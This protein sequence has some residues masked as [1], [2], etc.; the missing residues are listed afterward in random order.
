MSASRQLAVVSIYFAFA[1]LLGAQTTGSIEGVITDSTQ[2]SISGAAIMLRHQET[3][4][5]TATLTN[6][7]GYFLAD[8][9]PSG[10]YDVTANHP[11]FKRASLTG[12]RL[13]VATR[14]RHDIVLTVGDVSESVTVEAAAVHVNTSNATVS[15]VIT[16]KQIDT[17]VLNGRHFSRLAMLVPGAVYHS[18]S[19]ELFGAGLGATGSPVSINGV[20]NKASGWFVDG[21]YNMNVGNGEANQHVP[22]IDSLS[23]VQV[24]TAN[25]SARYGTTGGSV[26]TAI[27]KSGT[28]RFHGGAY[29]YLRND[30]LDARNFFSPSNPP[31]KQNQFG[32]LIG[33][34][35]ILPG[36][37]RDRNKTFF[38]WSEDWRKRRNALTRITATPD[39]ALREGN[40]ASE[41]V[42]T[43][44]PLLD[45][46]TGQRFPGN[47]IPAGRIDPNARLLLQTYFPAPNYFAEPFRNYL[48]NGVARFDTR[49][50]TVK[51]DH[52]ITDKYRLSGVISN[53]DINVL[54][55]DAG[56]GGSPFDVIRQRE[57][58]SGMNGNLRA[59]MAFTPRSIN[60]L[61]FAYKRFN[62]N[63]LFQ[64]AGASPVRP[65]GLNIR[66]F[67]EGANALNYTPAI[68]FAQGWGGIGTSQ[69]PLDPAGDNNFI[70]SDNHTFIAGNHTLQAGLSIMHYNKTQAA[71]NATQ[72]SFSFD[73]TF[74]NHPIG[75][76]L[77]G[78]ARTYSQ[79]KERFIRSYLFTQ[80]EAYLQ[81]DW[82]LTRK[83]TLN[84]GLRF[85][86]M[87]MTHV[88]DNLMSSFVPGRYDPAKAPDINAAGVLVPGP[89]YDRLNGI[90][91][92]EQDGVPRGFA[93]S[94]FALGP[95]FGFAYDVSGNGRMALRGGYGISYL[96]SGNNPSGL[97]NNP[98][99]NENIGL[100]NVSLVDPSGGVPNAPRPLALNAVHPDFIRP[101]VQSWSLSVQRELPAQFLASIAYVGTRGTHWEVW[102]DRNSSVFGPV[103]AGFDF[104][105]RLN[106]GF[107]ENLSRPF[108]GYATITQFNTGLSS[109]YHSLQTSFQRR[110]ANNVALQGAYTWSKAVGQAQTRRDMR[111]QNPLNWSADRGVLDYDRTHVLT[112]NYIYE[113]PFLRN[114]RDIL[115]QLLGNWQLSGLLSLQSG[116]ALT[117]GISLG[118]RGLATRPDATGEPGEGA[119]TKDDWFNRTAFRAPAPGRFGNAG[120]GTIRGPGFAIW[121][122]SLS[123]EF[124]IT[125]GAR[126]SLRGE[127]FNVL[128]HTNWSGVD[129]TLGSGTYGRVT[130]ARDPRRLQI[131][132][133]FDF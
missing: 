124:P 87:P 118:T 95:R 107:N 91:F 56:L 46:A 47:S 111:V 52:N 27:T 13:D 25:Y 74:T 18:G 60:E 127:F 73:G 50:D 106:A 88:R 12:I 36:Y 3:G 99:F 132:G 71:F 67:F 129:T 126:F 82:R 26:I 77:L 39:A 41:A 96:N 34:P 81:D 117:P 78:M 38:F 89:A 20:N 17:A 44:R 23:E 45:P 59:T 5:E 61:S 108:R 4:V 16:T 130:S 113:L 9:L 1:A 21:A 94:Y 114:R 49:T 22:V 15:T 119:G 37:N 40:F 57:N 6:A 104:D 121:D 125:E 65:S 80:T 109:T 19:D 10:T 90:V 64:E 2:A 75:D 31:L 69:L 55:P 43:G 29:E 58:T 42:R 68:S 51:I 128:N 93:D 11:G 35:V 133:R 123:K 70:L 122:A 53:D 79:G 63:L 97:V 116:L 120:V 32:F 102:L 92:P 28:S 100:Q 54:Q 112:M 110:F 131:A 103:P 7:A 14:A 98:P 76:F 62:V 48:N 33:G 105:P 115:G 84:L 66:D 8:N 86:A 30:A 72:G 85:Y 101:M 83:L 24:Q